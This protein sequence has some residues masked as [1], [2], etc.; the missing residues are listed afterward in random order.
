MKLHDTRLSTR[1]TV[2][3][4]LIVAVGVAAFLIFERAH[5]REAYINERS[6][7]LEKSLKVENVRLAQTIDA[8]RREVL[9]L[10]NIPGVMSASQSHGYDARDGSTGAQ[11]GERLNRIFSAFAAARPDCYLVR[12]IAVADGGKELV[13]VENRDGRVDV[14]PSGKLM[15]RGSLDGFKAASELREGQIWLSGFELNQDAGG[16]PKRTLRAVAPVFTPAGKLSGMVAVNLDV[17]RL[18]ES[19]TSGLPPGTQTYMANR[20]G[21]YLFHPDQRRAFRL[22]PDSRNEITADFPFIKTM[23]D[24]QAADY[25]A[26]H[27]L[28]AKTGKYAAAS[29]VYFD[30]GHP[31][32][33]LLLMHHIPDVVADS[34]ITSL[35][36]EGIVAGLIAMLLAG[37]IALLTMRRV[38]SALEQIAAAANRIAAGDQDI[39]LPKYGGGEIGSLTRALGA[40]LAR[41][42]QREKLLQE[43]ES[44]YRQLHE[45]LMD[46]FVMTDMQGRLLEFNSAYREMLG[47][48]AEELQR[49]TYIDLTP[50]KWHEFEARIVAEQVIPQGYS[51]VYEKEYMRKDGTII[52]VELKVFLLRDAN[53]QPEA[54]WAIVRDITGRKQAEGTLRRSET[55]LR[56]SQRMA[57]I[58]SW[59]LDLVN[60]ILYW[61]GE[62]YHIFGIDRTRFGAS[63]EAFLNTV[64]PDDRAMVNQAYTESVKNRMPYDI[65][66]RLLFPDGRVKYI[67]EWCETTY[68]REGRPVRSIGTT[69]DITA[70]KLDEEALRA[71]ENRYR[72]LIES[73]PFCIHEIDLEGR[74]QSMNRAGLDMLG[75]SDVEAIRGMPYL[76]AVSRQDAER[77]GALL[78]DAITV[79]T[80]SHFE[81]AAAGDAP[82]H[83]KSCFIPLKDSGGKVLKLMG[84]TEDITE[85]MQ[86]EEARAVRAHT[87]RFNIAGE[88]TISLTHELSQP[89]TACNNYLDVC[90]RRLD[91]K[92]WDREKLRVVLQL[93]YEQAGRAG[94]IINRFK[95]TVKKQELEYTLFDVN[96]LAREVVDFL[97]GEIKSQG[98]SAHMALSSLPQVMAC[99]EEIR[100]VLLN[101][102][103]NAI[104]A[105]HHSVQRE[106]RVTT[107]TIETGHILVAVSDS[108]EG[109]PPDRMETLFE[110]FQT[111]K[112]GRLGLNLSICRTIVERHG[113]R[114]WA[115]AQRESGAELYF[116]LP[117][118][119]HHE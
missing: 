89:L 94:E 49:L 29:R 11:W 104:E 93:A 106:L 68:D 24:P 51:Q 80:P 101:L 6:A 112:E 77:I 69:Q 117:V 54:M 65:T 78:R 108:G 5:H 58:G 87:G 81:F 17:S 67:R 111:S 19:T 26:L 52:P 44:K 9:F 32:H 90:L 107:S 1:I 95:D 42:S 27:E 116:T 48:S 18:L 62:N 96:L 99:R 71:S 118:E 36:A 98:I 119:A 46:A 72:L 57:Q 13:R 88:T 113:G 105:M 40:M 16:I 60:N 84:I 8:L 100:Q 110:P 79:G 37:V 86:L 30:P 35:P 50:E 3:T 59:E 102:C 103:E 41:L 91:E 22:G 28:E 114:V 2:I 43:S 4:L 10:S 21:Q 64:H 53:N 115:D 25:L 85:R 76:D 15:A 66:H 39:S 31:Q 73:S 55:M 45:S 23:F 83:F 97:A 56:E 47:Y 82:L 34:Q 74:L 38:F 61:S 7:D 70:H 109:I 92:D 33:F 63:Y 75:L 12:Y 20:D 14:A